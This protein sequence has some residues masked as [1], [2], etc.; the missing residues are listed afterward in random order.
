MSKVIYQVVQDMGHDG[1]ES[2][3]FNQTLAGATR[4]AQAQDRSRGYLLTPHAW[5]PRG[6]NMEP[7]GTGSIECS[8]PGCHTSIAIHP[9]GA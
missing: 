6:A 9:I 5:Q 1:T 4:R 7:D 2:I 3:G 8:V